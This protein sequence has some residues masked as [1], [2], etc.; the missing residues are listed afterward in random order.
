MSAWAI[1]VVSL[2]VVAGQNETVFAQVE[3]EC[4]KAAS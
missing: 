1:G 2:L 3:L 4:F